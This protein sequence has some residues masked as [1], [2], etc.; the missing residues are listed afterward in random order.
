MLYD[1]DFALHANLAFSH[2]LSDATVRRTI[3]TWVAWGW[4]EPPEEDDGYRSF[5]LTPKGGAVWESERQPLWHLYCTDAQYSRQATN[6]YWGQIISPSRQTAERFYRTA[7]QCSFFEGKIQHRSR[8]TRVL[9]HCREVWWKPF[10]KAIEIRFLLEENTDNYQWID[11]SIYEK[12]RRWWRTPSEL[13]ELR[14]VL[15]LSRSSQRS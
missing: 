5:S 6:T 2:E 3:E 10:P 4:L 1:E 14:Q 7:R 11:W 8:R 13:I 15:R 9:R 12:A